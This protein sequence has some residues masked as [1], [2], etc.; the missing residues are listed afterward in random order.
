MVE[1]LRVELIGAVIFDVEL[2]EMT[3]LMVGCTAVVSF[4]VETLLVMLLKVE[5]AGRRVRLLDGKAFESVTLGFS[6]AIMARDAW[7]GAD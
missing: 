5:F 3:T 7:V 2:L 1:T 4:I 6:K